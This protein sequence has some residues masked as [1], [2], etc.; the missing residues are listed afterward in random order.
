MTDQEKIAA[1]KES[2]NAH[3]DAQIR[4]EDL[5][6]KL[7]EAIKSE[8]LLGN[9]PGAMNRILALVPAELRSGK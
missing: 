9:S 6:R 7:A 8:S 1:Y 5:V 4:A 2:A 3:R